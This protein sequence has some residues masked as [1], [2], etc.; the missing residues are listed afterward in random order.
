MATA[1]QPGD[2]GFFSVLASAGSLSAAARELGITTPAVSKHLAQMEARAGVALVN[3][4]TRRM[5]LTPDGQVYLEHAR[6]ILD[7]MQ[8]MEE[9]LGVAKAVPKGLLRV[10]A[11]LGFGRGYVAPLISRFVAKY[12]QV[13][14]QLQLSVNPPPISE[15]LFDVCIRFGAPPDARVVARRIAANRRLLC[16]A[17]D[18]LARRGTPRTP[19]DLARH[20][21]IGIRQGEQAYGL[22]RLSSGRGRQARTVSVKTYGNLATNDGE[23]A[24][25]WALDGHGILMRAE[26]D[27]ARYLANGQLVQVL[28]QYATPDAD[29]YVVYDPRHQAAARVRAFVDFASR[30]LSFSP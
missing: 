3:R 15:D 5:S 9:S 20:N 12:P 21:C 10:N 28:P 24:V 2:L 8:A 18:Y 19:A 14:V 23:I 7:A 4:S 13:D 30:A 29:V 25:R 22:W 27:I 26:W 11:T 1:I 17:P 6:A 16:A